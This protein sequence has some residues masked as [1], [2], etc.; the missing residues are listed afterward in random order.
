M[1]S[2]SL[3]ISTTKTWEKDIVEI[4]DALLG[5]KEKTNIN[6]YHLR[7]PAI[8]YFVSYLYERLYKDPKK[9]F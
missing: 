4:S 6:Q 3:L 5:N 2:V 8:P 1:R 7:L 9:D